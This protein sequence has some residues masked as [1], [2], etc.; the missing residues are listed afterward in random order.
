MKILYVFRSLA[1][2]GGIE[3][4]L[5]EKMNHLATEYGYDVYMLTADQ[6]SHAVPYELDKKIHIEDLNVRIHQQYKYKGIY[7]LWKH[8]QL[9]RRFEQLLKKRIK[10]IAPDVI[11]CVATSYAD[12]IIKV[13]GKIPVVVESHSICLQTLTSQ[14]LS[15]RLQTYLLKKRLRKAHVIVALTEGDAEEWRKH[16]PHVKVIPN[17]VHL[18][19]A[20]ISKQTSRHAIFV[21]RFDNQKRAIEAIKLWEMIQADFPDWTLDIYGEGEQQEAVV[22]T[23]QERNLNIAVHEPTPHIFDCYRESSFLISTSS[24]EPFGLV[25]PEAMSCGLPVIAYDCP[26]GPA[27]IISDGN[28]GF[29]IKNNDRVHFA[30]R[31]K[32]L[33][34]DQELRLRMGRSAATAVQRFAAHHIMPQWKEL[35]EGLVH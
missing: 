2:W 12:S 26:Y 15:Q 6:G 24:F 20:F 28:D 11:V 29:L 27:S 1:I 10:E 31:M 33:M 7:R 9:K 8:V 32:L 13:S 30:E 21:G 3:R 25:I 17:I 14:G 16:Y 35:F 34:G 18:N 19:E 5:V 23:I 22:Q 4:I